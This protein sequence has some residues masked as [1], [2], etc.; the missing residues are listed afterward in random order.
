MFNAGVKK[1]DV[2]NTIE[3]FLETK[4][5]SMFSLQRAASMPTLE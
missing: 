4:Q 1:F 2:M 5:Y 3:N